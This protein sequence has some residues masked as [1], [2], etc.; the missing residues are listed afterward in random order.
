M[1]SKIP[2]EL[3][4][5]L[6]CFLS[7][8][9]YW[10]LLTTSKRL[11]ND[12]S[13]ISRRISLDKKQSLNLLRNEEFRSLILGKIKDPKHQLK[14][15]L[16]ESTID[17]SLLKNIICELE[18]DFLY[19]GFFRFLTSSD[20]E[21]FFRRSST[22]S[23]KYNKDIT[24]FSCAF[25]V[26]RVELKLFHGLRDV[27]VFSNV[28]E[29]GLS[30]CLEVIDVNCLLNLSKLTIEGC[31]KVTDV[32]A[33]GKV[34]YLSITQCDQIRDISALTDNYWLTVCYC[35]GLT[36]FPSVC[37]AFR[38]CC[39]WKDSEFSRIT[40]PFLRKLVL[41]QS[42]ISV[43]VTDRFLAGLFSV[44]LKLCDNLMDLSGCHDIP[45][46]SVDTCRYLLDISD[47]G[48]NQSV[49]IFN[50]QMITDFS[51]LPDIPKVS[52][53]GC[54]GFVDGCDVGNVRFLE[55]KECRNFT[56]FSAL[57]GVYDL[58]LTAYGKS[59]A[60]LSN[61]PILRFGYCEYDEHATW[62][63]YLKNREPKNQK[64]V[65]S[66]SDLKPLQEN[67]FPF[68]T[69]YDICVE[70]RVVTLFLKRT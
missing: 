55:I 6:K 35:N 13:F 44:E 7:D 12:L 70:G 40:F 66:F 58:N 60:G 42:N 4:L 69:N 65:F 52:I 37:N 63:D 26:E 51:S 57:G 24:Q 50:C 43:L 64:I 61:V 16:K 67:V 20:W 38:L 14:L 5:E 46:V 10:K 49:T 48:N 59:F 9:Q 31:P 19:I 47:L 11:L 39:N 68:I 33:L 2:L 25:D 32:S 17:F 22:L 34:R 27:S 56:N 62:I 36:A 23:L 1:I 53:Q 41:L 21:N 8:L 45:V 30:R 29:L 3:Y 15:V 18:I 28:K 54:K